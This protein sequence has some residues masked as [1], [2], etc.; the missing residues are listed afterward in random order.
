LGADFQLYPN[1]DAMFFPEPVP[2]PDGLP[3][4]AMLHR[5]MWDLSWISE[6]AGEPLP[7]DLAERRPG[8]WVSYAPAAAVEADV[9]ALARLQQ[10]RLVAL[11]EQSWEA[12]KIGG[13][14]APVRVV[15]GWLTLFHGVAGELVRDSVLQPKVRYAAGA[16]ILD[17]ADVARVV[18]RSAR[19]LLE[20]EL[21]EE[22]EGIV[23]NV[24]FPTALERVSDAEAFVFYG[25]ADSRIGVARLR[26]TD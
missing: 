3:S 15:E 20:P 10:H 2:G 9:R 25:M 6:G 19:P 8:I 24:V 16:L 1:K 5:P 4:Y 7:T 11:P 22:R 12:L 26:R 21:V 17:T 23:P 13:G 18:A 14:T